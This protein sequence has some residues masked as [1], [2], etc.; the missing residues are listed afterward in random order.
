MNMAL[1]IAATLLLVIL[2]VLASWLMLPGRSDDIGEWI[3]TAMSE[4]EKEDWVA[5]GCAGTLVFMLFLWAE[6]MR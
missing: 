3:Y 5:M 2:A 4:L 6:V 1:Q